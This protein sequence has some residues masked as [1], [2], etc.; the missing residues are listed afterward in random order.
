[1]AKAAPAREEVLEKLAEVFRR[2][3]F[4]G[5]SMSDFSGATGLGKSSLY[6]L[7]P[8]GKEEIACAVL[9]RAIASLERDVIAPLKGP[10][11]P[12]ARLAAMRRELD[13]LHDGGRAPCLLAA[14][15]IERT[16]ALFQPRLRVVFRTWIAALSD[17]LRAAGREPAEAR[18][19]AEEA[20]ARLQGALVLVA[21]LEETAPFRRALG[22]I[23]RLLD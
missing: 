17:L 7:F 6:H 20:I 16:R 3:G 8:G 4:E 13:A 14:F 5:A 22:E 15:A 9:D 11:T 18:R 19:R 10:G 23:E 21:G 1:M 2:A 12:R